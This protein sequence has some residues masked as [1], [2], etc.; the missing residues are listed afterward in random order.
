MDDQL[1]FQIVMKIHF[2]EL[3]SWRTTVYPAFTDDETFMTYSTR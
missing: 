1:Y 3:V 2:P